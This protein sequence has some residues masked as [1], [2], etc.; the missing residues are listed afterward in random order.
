MATVAVFVAIGGTSYA[1]MTLPRDSVNARAIEAGAVNSS[2]LHRGAVTSRAIR[3]GAIGLRDLASSTRISLRGRR[4]R[5][6][7]QG[8][9][10][11]S[12]L[13]LRASLDSNGELLAG[14]A[15]NTDANGASKRLVGFSRSLAGCVPIATLARNPIG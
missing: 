12:A 4:G 13:D 5:I 14:T 9:I 15:T 6:G 10:G 7:P 3:N 8:P 11:A 1:A 2:E